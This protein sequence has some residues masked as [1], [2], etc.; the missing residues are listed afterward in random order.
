MPDKLTDLQAA[1]RALPLDKALDTLALIE[2]LTRNVMKD[3]REPK[4]RKINL[5]NEK[6]RAIITDVPNAIALLN[7]MGWVRE[8]DS[9]V[10]PETVRMVHE[11]HIVGLIEAQDHYKTVC[12][13]EKVR[14]MRAAK[15]PTDADAEKTRQQIEADR[16]EKAA[17][18]PVTQGSKAN[19][20]GKGKSMTAS[21]LGIGQG[22]GG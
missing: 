18:G 17:E 9:L 2:K 11:T 7:E 14:L 16:K 20:L 22:G 8:A 21:D 12:E 13:K 19:E 3:Q 5:A 4:F 1:M 6:I 15:A 10:L